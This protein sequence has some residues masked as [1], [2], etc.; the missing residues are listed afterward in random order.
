M[1]V[2]ER[3]EG[4]GR[5]MALAGKDCW[6]PLGVTGRNKRTDRPRRRAVR[7]SGALLYF[8]PTPRTRSNNRSPGAARADLRPRYAEG[9]YLLRSHYNVAALRQFKTANCFTGKMLNHRYG[10]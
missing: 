10:E 5:R 7:A 4:F 8:C 2:H 3:V 6:R 9:P 1:R